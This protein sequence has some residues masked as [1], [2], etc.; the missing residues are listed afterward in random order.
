[1][2]SLLCGCPPVDCFQCTA[3]RQNFPAGPEDLKKDSRIK[4]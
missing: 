1:M 3:V 4:R 2:G